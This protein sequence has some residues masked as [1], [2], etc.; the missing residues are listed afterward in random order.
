MGSYWTFETSREEVQRKVVA[1]NSGP[2]SFIRNYN[3]SFIRGPKLFLSQFI[4]YMLIVTFFHEF[5]LMVA[6]ASYSRIVHLLVHY[7]PEY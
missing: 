1:P 7:I 3:L 5:I 6:D 2:M 4:V